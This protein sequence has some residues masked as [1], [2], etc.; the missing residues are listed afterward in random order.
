MMHWLTKL[1]EKSLSAKLALLAAVEAAAFAVSSPIAWIVGGPFGL[2]AA[3]IAA[4]A[5]LAGGALA[6]VISSFFH[7]P[8]QAYAGVLLG[9]IVGMGLPLAVG[10]ACHLSG[11]DLS[12]AGVMFYLL[13]FFPV[14]LMA[15]TVLSLPI[16]SCMHLENGQAS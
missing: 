11:G 2:L 4:T 10:I 8:Q 12:R 16:A 6:L 13:Y 9:M 7:D 1:R 5:C 15:K 14:T 3:T